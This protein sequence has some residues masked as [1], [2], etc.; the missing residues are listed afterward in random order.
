MNSIPETNFQFPNQ[1][2]FYKGK[3]RD[4]YS[5]EDKLVMV[6]TDRISA[7]DV[8]LPKAIPYKGQVLNQIAAHFLSA[9]SD[10]VPN[11][12]QEVPDPNVSMGIK[13]NAFPVE[14]V[15]RGYL[16]GHAWR[17]YSAGKREVCG[18]SLPDGLKENDKLPTPI[19]TPTTKAHEGHDEDISKEEILSHGLVSED[20]YE[21]LER[22]TLALFNRGTEMAADQGLI[23]VDTK[24]EF[25]ELNGTIYL[26]DEIHTPDSSRYFYKDT[27]EENQRLNQPQK[28]LSKEF[29]REW[30][31]QNGFQ[32]KEGQTVPA[33][34]EAWIQQISERYI[35]LFEKVSGRKFQKN[36]LDNPLQRIEKAILRALA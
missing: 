32:G 20:N 35:E 1:T 12:L 7:F 6:A 19:I 21:H 31:I 33:M 16:A 29:V 22:Y 15:V 4:V 3:V 2:G 5:F 8:I 23:L 10:I 26:I 14:M 34:E 11:W 13:C 9:T 36:N 28:Q 24:Y 25:G 27:Y 30:L 18:V 17:E